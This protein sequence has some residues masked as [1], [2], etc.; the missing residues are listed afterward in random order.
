MI[1]TIIITAQILSVHTHTHS[2]SIAKDYWF[3]KSV[4]I[5]FYILYWN[6]RKQK[7]KLKT[8]I[9]SKRDHVS[10]QKGG[11]KKKKK[12]QIFFLL[13]SLSFLYLLWRTCGGQLSHDIHKFKQR[14][15]RSVQLFMKVY[16]PNWKHSLPKLWKAQRRRRRSVMEKCVDGRD[17]L[18]PLFGKA[19]PLIL[20]YMC[21]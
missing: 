14:M 6:I 7:P 15:A 11:S 16:L 20:D 21:K 8:T 9:C 19:W 3:K 2:V 1:S 17:T 18:L 4:L 5:S 13:V 10:D 12:T